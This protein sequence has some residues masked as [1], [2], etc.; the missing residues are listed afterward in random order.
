MS[1]LNAECLRGR[2]LTTKLRQHTVWK[3]SVGQ[4]IRYEMHIC[5]YW[6]A[7]HHRNRSLLA[8]DFRAG[9]KC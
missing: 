6:I 4:R 9:V 5:R 7:L 8:S 2:M 3:D 1:C